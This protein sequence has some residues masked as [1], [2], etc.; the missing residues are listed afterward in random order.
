MDDLQT[1]HGVQLVELD[2]T[3]PASVKAAVGSVIA[4]AGRIDILVNNAGLRQAASVTPPD[5]LLA[6]EHGRRSA[7]EPAVL[8]H[9]LQ[10]VV[11]A[12]PCR[13]VHTYTLLCSVSRSW[14]PQPSPC[15][16][17]VTRAA[18]GSKGGLSAWGSK[19]SYS[20][21]TFVCLLS[22]TC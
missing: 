10:H 11:R 16:H 19:H 7:R 13:Q 2:V 20:V 17:A 5:I 1:E 4:A 12:Q 15:Q 21:C 22:V 9:G 6:L 8:L 14:T 18:A 3:D